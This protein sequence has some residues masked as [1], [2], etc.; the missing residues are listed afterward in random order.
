[1]TDIEFALLFFV[2]IPLIIWY[3]KKKGNFIANIFHV[4]SGKN[5]WIGYRKEKNTYEN[6]PAL[7]DGILHPGDIFEGIILD[8][9]KTARINMLYAKDYSP[10][11]DAEILLKS[12]KKLDR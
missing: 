6:L 9:E 12:W 3:F 11:K 1:M 5:T 8:N 7:K 10:L 2:A 4:L